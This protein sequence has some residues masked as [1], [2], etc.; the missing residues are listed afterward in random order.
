MYC[1]VRVHW[2]HVA[3]QIYFFWESAVITE[4]NRIHCF[5]KQQWQRVWKSIHCLLN[6]QWSD[7]KRKATSIAF[8]R[9]QWKHMEIH[10]LF[11]KCAMTTQGKQHV[12]LF[13]RGQ[14]QR[15]ENHIHCFAKQQW[16]YLWQS[17]HCL[18]NMKWQY[19]E[20]CIHSFLKERSDNS[21]K[22]ISTAWSSSSKNIWKSIH[23]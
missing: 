3:N 15:V 16:Q 19:Q 21:R 9:E 23:C 8:S 2:Q 6:M 17:I 10:I 1:L 18:V 20:N 13:E 11:I 5:V 12:M 22:I 4:D 7:S 14:L